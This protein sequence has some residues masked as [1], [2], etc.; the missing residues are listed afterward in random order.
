[1]SNLKIK[2][3]ILKKK[4]VIEFEKV[5]FNKPATKQV[6]VKISYTGICASQ[7]ME[8]KGLRG[9]DSWLPHMF[10]HE[11]SGIIID[12][13]KGVKNFKI[14]DKVIL[15]WLKNRNKG[16]DISGCIYKNKKKI[17]FGPVTTFASHSLISENRIY[18]LPRN[19]KLIDAA[20]FGC[21][22][23]TG[24]GLVVN[25]AK[26][27]KKD[28]CLVA[29]L[30]GVGVFCLI[31][32]KALGIKKIIGVDIS[33][34]KINYLKKLGFNNLMNLKN[35]NY[36]KRLMKITN[37]Q[38]IDFIFETTG[39]SNSIQNL[40]KLLNDKTGKL[41]FSSHPKKGE[42]ISLDPHELIKGKKIFG[43]WGGNSNLNKD[44]I[45]FNKLIK[46][47]KIKLNKLYR[48]YPFEKLKKLIKSFPNSTEPR[49]VLRLS[50]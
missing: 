42:K 17:N 24:M 27:N 11:G 25:E 28:I 5:S 20:L 13:G 16:D 14:G 10:G 36:L 45:I 41:Y 1:M 38:K 44:I 43:S 4:N 8:F 48:V 32:L 9:K 19:I 35:K 49:S 34:K 37:N 2:I 3:A 29:G 46:K 50:N 7:F 26:P 23:P 15:S 12:K 31:A 39:K 21:A 22:I 33:N 40:F 6:L 47:S 30:G 18:K